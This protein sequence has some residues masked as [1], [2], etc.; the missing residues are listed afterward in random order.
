MKMVAA[1]IISLSSEIPLGYVACNTSV[2]FETTLT[3]QRKTGAGRNDTPKNSL[4]FYGRA[5]QPAPWRGLGFGQPRSMAGTG[6]WGL[7]LL[8]SAAALLGA[9]IGRA[10]LQGRLWPF[11]SS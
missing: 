4:C 5:N 6:T 11:R 7:Q 8:S 10:E 3:Y 1:F 9:Q 2:V